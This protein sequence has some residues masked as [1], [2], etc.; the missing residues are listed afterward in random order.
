MEQ[1]VFISHAW[2]E[3]PRADEV[4]FSLKQAGIGVVI[5]RDRNRPGDDVVRFIEEAL[6][7]CDYCLLLW[8]KAAGQRDWVREEWHA[9]LHRTV[10]EAR[11]F[12]LVAR[13]E[14]HPLP[15]LLAARLF[16]N[17]FPNLRPG[18][19]RIID[20]CRDD[21]A[22]AVSTG[23]PVAQATA[24]ITED[25]DGET[26]YVTSRIF[27]VTTPLRVSMDIPCG[28]FLDRFLSDLML[29]KQQD[30]QGRLGVRYEYSLVYQSHSLSP[31]L[32][33]KS[34]GVQPNSPLELEVEMQPFSAH[35]PIAGALMATTFRGESD[36]EEAELLEEARRLLIT[37]VNRA[38]LG[39]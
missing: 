34:Q 5:D 18:I 22:A 32:S 8:S 3:S 31:G 17:L 6:T 13:L 24:E 12:L 39:F 20:I 14:D 29:P 25:P 37:A 27:Q 38:G 19:D 21:Q 28:V 16:E 2:S 35:P 10:K 4:A 26:I 9:A 11:R 36:E 15:A 7:M 33:L 30:L 1:Q 23:R